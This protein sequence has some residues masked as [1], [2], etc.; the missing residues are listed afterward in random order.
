MRLSR[1]LLGYAL[2][3]ALFDCRAERLAAP[4]PPAELQPSAATAKAPQTNPSTSHLALGDRISWR[5]WESAQDIARTDGKSICL[6]VYANWCS[7]CKELAPVF[8]QAEVASAAEGLAMV[9]Q[10]Q[11]EAPAWLKEKFGAYGDYVPRVFFV[12][13][14]GRVRDDLTS[15]HPRYPH[16]Y[17]PVITDQLVMNMRA[18][19]AR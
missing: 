7:H 16:F 4:R 2:L 9:H 19:S 10:D 17:A 13:P 15:G 1:Q 14:D 12:S 8:A 3:I 18:A 5:S 11:D 6:V